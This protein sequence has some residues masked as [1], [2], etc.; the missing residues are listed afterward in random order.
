MT[1]V[2]KDLKPGIQRID[3]TN[4]L[5]AALDFFTADMCFIYPKCKKGTKSH[6]MTDLEGVFR[7]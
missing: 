4:M 3:M 1:T 2:I 6:R 7:M 5:D